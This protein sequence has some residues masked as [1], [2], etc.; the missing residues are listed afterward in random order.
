M[1]QVRVSSS[2]SSRHRASQTL[3]DHRRRTTTSQQVCLGAYSL[4]LLDN[5]VHFI[6]MIVCL[7]GPP[8]HNTAAITTN[9]ALP[10]G[11][12]GAPNAVLLVT[13]TKIEYDV[14]VDVLQQVFQK[15]GAVQK[16]VTYW[17]SNEF[18]ALVQMETTAQAQAAQAALDGRD[19]YTGCNQLAIA[20]SRHA[21]VHVRFNNER[22]RDFTNP[23][24]TPGDGS[25]IHDAHEFYKE[26][27]AAFMPPPAATPVAMAP[28]MPAASRSSDDRGRSERDYGRAGPGGR[29]SYDPRDSGRSSR[30]D[31]GRDDAYR[32]ES[33]YNDSRGPPLA[34][35]YGD[36]RG[37]SGP[38][39]R[40]MREPRG[41]PVSAAGPLPSHSTGRSLHTEDSRSA[42][43]ICSSI[44]RELMVRSRCSDALAAVLVAIAHA[45]DDLAIV[46]SRRPSGSSRSLGATATS[47]A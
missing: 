9:T 35:R 28:A 43:L 14:T 24:L 5:D 33:R 25:D 17:Q 42:V 32:S 18:K 1:S 13:V 38:D 34:S 12:P 11:G 37:R 29:D 27:T 3:A 39:D 31:Y 46:L 45:C 36:S 15:F 16:I 40:M 19:I 10:R 44:D 22:S 47:S 21:D 20:F 26:P 23:Y 6:W 8:V 41:V 2:S 30:N 7:G 4:A